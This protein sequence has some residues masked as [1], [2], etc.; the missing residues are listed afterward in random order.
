MSIIPKY[1]NNQ[2]IQS[3]QYELSWSDQIA[4]AILFKKLGQ[5]QHGFLQIHTN[6]M[7]YEFGNRDMQATLHAV[8]RVNDIRVFK[9]ILFGGEPAAGNTY[10]KDWWTS[11]NLLNVMRLFTLNR[12]VL[13]SFKSGTASIAKFIYSV[14]HALNK[15]DRQGSK[16]N[17]LA[18]YDIGNDLYRL[19]LDEKMMYS[20]AC[21]TSKYNN[22]EDASEYKLKVICEK[23]KLTPSDHLLEIGSGW[24]GFAMYAAKNYGCKVTTTTISDQQYDYVQERVT[25]NNLSEQVTILK[26]DYRTLEGQYDKLV[27]IEMIESVGHQYLDDYFS[28]C[29]KLLKPDGVF[30]IQAITISDYLYNRYLHSMDFIRKYVFPGGSLPSMSSML[31]SVS[32]NSDLTLFHAESYASSYGK[33]LAIWYQRFINN[34]DKVTELGYGQSFIRL[35]EYYL[36]YCQAGFEERVI[37]V[38]QLVLKKPA[39]RFQS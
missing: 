1:K 3:F 27:S 22:L 38:Q 14:G 24:G 35:W 12:D 19:F 9:T 23:L 32:N 30:L 10:V 29:S 2:N 20:S 13:F 26:Q 28:I 31:N 37:D 17:I 33:T 5:I 6:G 11:E 36:K 21:F 15:N 4:Q 8:I 7:I 25:A 34:K 39:N 18:H 16:R